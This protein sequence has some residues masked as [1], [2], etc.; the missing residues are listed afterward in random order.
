MVCSQRVIHGDSVYFT[1]SSDCC[2]MLEKDDLSRSPTM[3]GGTRKMR[4]ISSIWNL[5]V[6]RNCACSGEMEMGL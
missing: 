2:S 4:A 6:S 3:W 1:N 5:R